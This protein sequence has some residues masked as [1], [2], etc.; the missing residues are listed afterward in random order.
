MD[1]LAAFDDWRLDRTVEVAI[2]LRTVGLI[3]RVSINRLIAAVLDGFMPIKGN[4]KFSKF[5]AKS[6][7]TDAF[8]FGTKDIAVNCIVFENG[9]Q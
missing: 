7:E 1:V 3:I 5:S 8:V 6:I 4:E 9:T 2:H